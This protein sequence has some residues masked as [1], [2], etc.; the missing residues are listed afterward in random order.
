MAAL[1][2]GKNTGSFDKPDERRDFQGHGHLDVINFEGG[3]VVGRGVFEPG[4]RWSNDVKP[5]A[6]TETCQAAHVGYCLK[7]RMTIHMDNGEE[8]QIKAGD[9]YRIIP[10]HDAW[11]EGSETCEMLDFM[12]YSEYAVRKEPVKKSA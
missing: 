7:G 3:T 6:E 8:F 10:G 2:G 4:W 12:G 5:I 11:V 1:K 9:A